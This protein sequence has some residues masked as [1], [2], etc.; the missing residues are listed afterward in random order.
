MKK[1]KIYGYE[2]GKW[3][4]VQWNGRQLVK[5][6][7]KDIKYRSS[8]ASGDVMWFFLLGSCIIRFII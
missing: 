1:K 4:Y 5:F 3:L 2:Q 6:Q 8:F 7:T